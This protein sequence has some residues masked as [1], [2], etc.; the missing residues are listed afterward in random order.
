M[1]ASEKSVREY[2][3]TQG[4][5]TVVYEPDGKVPPDFLVDGRIAVEVRRL[6]QNEETAVGHRG[7][8][9][10]SRPLN[11]LV[12]KAL[13]AMG[14]PVDGTSWFAS[15]TYR[16]PLPPWRKLDDLLRKALREVAARP[17]HA[18]RDVR[19]AAKLRL[20]FTRA[21]EVHPTLFVLGA[22]SDNDSGGFVVS[23]MARNIQICIAEKASKVSRVRFRYSEWWLAL[24]DRIGY[25]VLDERD[26]NQLRE[27]VHVDDL[28]SKV[29]LVNPLD[30]F[31]GFAL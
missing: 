22:W 28:W 15:Y 16:R 18:G 9:E 10:V 6:N 1:N 11:V 14:P 19:V 29:I 31:I 7:L 8:E 13:A 2:L 25:G 4:F 20:S 3:M 17:T 21:S 30:P 24:E 26:R 5:R 27:L 12:K 23:E